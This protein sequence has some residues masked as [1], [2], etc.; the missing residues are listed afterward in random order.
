MTILY[1]I[2]YNF[3]FFKFGNFEL[4]R[5]EKYGWDKIYISYE[6]IC[7]DYKKGDL[8]PNDLK[9]NTARIINEMI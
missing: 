7:E 9:P 6:E 2:I 5:I 1:L 4:K 3:Y 8:D